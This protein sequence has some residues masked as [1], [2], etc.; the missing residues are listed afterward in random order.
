MVKKF[1][2]AL[3]LGVALF[4]CQ[5]N[6][7]SD[8]PEKPIGWEI[9]QTPVQSSLRGLSVVTAEIVWASG[10]DGVW[11]RTVDGG[12][13]WD[14]G[15]IGGLDSVDFRSIHAVNALT[16][17]AVSA[18]QPAV[19]Y[20]TVDGGDSWELKHRETS[21]EAFFDGI[22]FSDANIGYV[23]GDPIDGKW[24]ILHT[25]NQGES[26][27]S[28]DSLPMVAEGEA[29]F[30]ASASSFL[31]HGSDLWL[32][33]GGIES[34]LYHSGNEGRTWNKYEAPVRK[35]N[36]SQGIFSITSIGKGEIFVVGGDYLEPDSEISNSA[37]FLEKNGKWTIPATTP[38]GYRSG[39][40]YFPGAHWLL[41][42]GPGGSDY[43][44]DGGLN[45]GRFS[46]EGF[47]AI[48]LGHTFGTIWAS[49]AGGK[50]GKLVY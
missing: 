45:W 11:L 3:L 46:D 29:A 18:G 39:V 16:A 27:H 49:G 38:S 25:A 6:T 32:G 19:I 1:L 10:S 31:A 36:P 4:S 23:I 14:H 8:F 17:V 12:D 50:V 35:G 41:A 9:K 47:H 42:V 40:A 34:N 20:K 28:V 7:R 5:R 44:S 13:T 15:I 2:A 21:E 33:S 24:M 37:I 26:W 43:S 30:A 22:S 48:R